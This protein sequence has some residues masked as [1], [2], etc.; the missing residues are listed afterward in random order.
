MQQRRGQEAPN[1][2]SRD[3]AVDLGPPQRQRVAA[4]PLRGECK[5][6]GHEEGV[7]R[8]AQRGAEIK[9]AAAAWAGE[10]GAAGPWGEVN[11][12]RLVGRLVS[13]QHVGGRRTGH[14]GR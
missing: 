12:H 10:E 5:R 1:L 6:I 11:A 3:E 7:G 8:A 13:L 9:G 4:Q 2:A 14:H